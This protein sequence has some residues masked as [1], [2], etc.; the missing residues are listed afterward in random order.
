MGAYAGISSI[1]DV[2]TTTAQMPSAVSQGVLRKT[3]MREVLYSGTWS[4]YTLT[5][6]SSGSAFVQGTTTTG[7]YYEFTFWGTGVDIYSQTNA[8]A[9]HNMAVT[10][11][12]NSNLSSIT[13]AFISSTT[14]M[15]WATNPATIGG[16][17]VAVSTYC[18]RISGLTLGKH[19]VRVTKAGAGDT[20][21]LNNIDVITPIH[22]YQYNKQ[23]PKFL[24]GG[25][26]TTREIYPESYVAPTFTRADAF[27]K[28]LSAQLI[29]TATPDNFL[30]DTKV[31][32]VMKIMNGN[33]GR[34]YAPFKGR[35]SLKGLSTFGGNTSWGVGE[36]VQVFLAV[37]GDLKYII[38]GEY[39][40]TAS[41]SYVEHMTL[42][43]DGWPISEGDII[44]V[45]IIQNSGANL[46]S[47][48]NDGYN[49]V[50]ITFEKDV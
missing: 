4:A 20:L 41:V 5:V 19:V 23:W 11:D 50:L 14:G 9:A 49:W 27:F 32:D 29:S 26:T 8:G 18:L 6:G 33:N 21:Y 30:Y 43:G 10:V 47:L 1:P 7:A 40:Q 48:A 25:S 12:T 34:A 44:T 31:S 46:S 45:R 35:F 22:S 37:N 2:L 38:G 36:Q 39:P 16:T 3:S 42:V 13:T 28:D 15:T 24:V 17:P